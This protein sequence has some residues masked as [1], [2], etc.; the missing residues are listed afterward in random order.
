MLRNKLYIK[1]KYKRF[2]NFFIF[3]IKL[4]ID[5]FIYELGKFFSLGRMSYYNPLIQPIK[6]NK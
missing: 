4:L 1:K 6:K 3:F 2:N 5:Y